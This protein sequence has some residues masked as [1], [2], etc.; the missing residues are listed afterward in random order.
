M[1]Q[2]RLLVMGALIFLAGCSSSLSHTSPSPSAMPSGSSSATSENQVAPQTPNSFRSDLEKL[3]KKYSGGSWIHAHSCT[4]EAEALEDLVDQIDITVNA[5]SVSTTER[6]DMSVSRH[7]RSVVRSFSGEN[8]KGLVLHRVDGCV[9]VAINKDNAVSSYQQDVHDMTP[10]IG[11]Y[12]AILDDPRGSSTLKFRAAKHLQKILTRIKEDHAA[13]ALF[14]SPVKKLKVSGQH[15]RELVRA[16]SFSVVAI[17]TH[18]YESALHA[19]FGLAPQPYVDQE[20]QDDISD[21][22]TKSGYFVVS[23]TERPAFALKLQITKT[24]SDAPISV[25]SVGIPYRL[26]VVLTIKD[27]HTGRV[28]RTRKE[29]V[30][31]SAINFAPINTPLNDPGIAKALVLP[32]VQ[33]LGEKDDTTFSPTQTAGESF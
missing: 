7:R 22:L 31:L 11:R 14:G 28:V 33:S 5:T 4:S 20:E 2:R 9:F 21:A 3:S 23:R 27:L 25:N 10:M 17:E 15:M 18:G 30:E 12:F 32:A 1:T 29:S 8:L 6:Q 13:L 19:P 24:L 16:L 26:T